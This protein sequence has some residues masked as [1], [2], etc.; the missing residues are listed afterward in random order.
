MVG[1]I[2]AT[3]SIICSRLSQLRTHTHQPGL[4]ERAP[5]LINALSRLRRSVPKYE[6]RRRRRRHARVNIEKSGVGVGGVAAAA[7]AYVCVSL[8]ERRESS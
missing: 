5:C 2:D 8:S 3:L 6:R 1:K 7:A 4:G